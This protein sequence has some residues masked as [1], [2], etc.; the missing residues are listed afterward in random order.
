MPGVMSVP[1][2]YMP[3]LSMVV[4][5][6]PAGAGEGAGD[7]D[8][9]GEAAGDGD[10]DGEGDGAG[11]GS[12]PAT[13]ADAAQPATI[14]PATANLAAVGAPAFSPIAH[15]PTGVS[16]LIHKAASRGSRRDIVRAATLGQSPH[17]AGVAE[18]VL[19]RLEVVARNPRVHRTLEEETQH[20]VVGVIRLVECQHRGAVGLFLELVVALGAGPQRRPDCHIA[21]QLVDLRLGHGL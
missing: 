21:R 6:A 12:A 18:R 20:R 3:S 19:V 17:L 4:F 8:G 16:R 13:A 9:S 2:A 7:A 1:T 11:S 15:Q 10:A 5:G 14:R